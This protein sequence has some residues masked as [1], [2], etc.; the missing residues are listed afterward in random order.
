MPKPAGPTGG[1]DVDATAYLAAVVSAG[2]TVDG[3]I[4]TAVNTLFTS[5]KSN[6]L[7]TKIYALYPFIGSTTASCAIEAKLTSGYNLSY[8]GS[9]ASANA[10]GLSGNGSVGKLSYSPSSVFTSANDIHISYYSRTSRSPNASFSIGISG[11][12]DDFNSKRLQLNILYDSNTYLAIGSISSLVAYTDTG[13]TGF[14]IG[15]RTAANSLKLYKNGSMVAQSTSSTTNLL[16]STSDIAVLGSIYL[17][18]PSETDQLQSAFY[19]LGSGLTDG[20][21][22]T[23]YTI[24]QAFQTSLGRQV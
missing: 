11:P 21:S 6:G 3:T 5:L 23:Y 4:T 17:G 1:G 20:E 13:T 15:S 10:N 14:Y 19:S 7:Y 24:V 22:S 8:L 16:S 18:N 2:G 12:I 9:G